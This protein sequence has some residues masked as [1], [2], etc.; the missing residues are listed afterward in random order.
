LERNYTFG[1]KCSEESLE[2]IMYPRLSHFF[3]ML[4]F[5]IIVFTLS[6]FIIYAMLTPKGLS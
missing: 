2:N 1:L 6:D 5:G 4:L 3:T